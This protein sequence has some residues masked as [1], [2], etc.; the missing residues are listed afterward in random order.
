A[1]LIQRDV[2][3]KDGE[4]SAI[5]SASNLN[6]DL[7]R[8]D[9]VL[10]DKTG[11]LTE[12]RMLFRMCS[13]GGVR[14]GDNNPAYKTESPR[15]TMLHSL[16][17]SE[18]FPITEKSYLYDEALLDLLGVP[19]ITKPEE[20]FVHAFMLTC[21]MCN[22]IIPEA[23]GRSPI[24]V[25]FEGASSDEET[26]VQMAA[27]SGYILVG[28]NANYVTLRISHS[29]AERN[30]RQWHESIFKIL[31]VNEFTSERKRMSVLVQMLRIA[32][33]VN[34]DTTHVPDSSGSILLVKG[35]D[36]VVMELSRGGVEG[37][38]SMALCG[39]PVQ[40]V[41]EATVTHIH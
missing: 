18:T 35:A 21:A 6:D 8:V 25:R 1:Y 33:D 40:D 30:G 2:H 37:D 9:Y 13:I 39:V 12:N 32:E 36:D 34:G 19:A 17:S 28:R 41:R 11:T 4:H 26:L 14:Y 7:G 5:V 27:S 15:S 38:S 16:G 31:G 23:T 20:A 22:T 10:A 29:A 3:L 24:G